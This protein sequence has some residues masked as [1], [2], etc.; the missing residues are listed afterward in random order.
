[1]RYFAGLFYIFMKKRVRFV[2]EP[3][4]NNYNGP[5]GLINMAF[6]EDMLIDI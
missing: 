2:N 4:T 6:N 3:K 5:F 1:M